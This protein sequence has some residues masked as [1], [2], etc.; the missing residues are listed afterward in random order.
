MV[1]SDCQITGCE[2]KVTTPTTCSY[3]DRWICLDHI[4]DR[5]QCI[6]VECDD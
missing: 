6:C 4:L 1:L 5:I 2:N 3:C